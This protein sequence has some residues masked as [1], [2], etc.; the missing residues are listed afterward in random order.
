[1]A[2]LTVGPLERARD[3]HARVLTALQKPGTQAALAAVLG[4]SEPTISR[5]KNERLE[6]SIAFLYALGFK[7]VPQGKVCVDASEIQMLR[8]AYARVVQNEAVAAQLFGDDE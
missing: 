1:M 5:I 2:S 3:A 4:A 6:E 8:R 7:L